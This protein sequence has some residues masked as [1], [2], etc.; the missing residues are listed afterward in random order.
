MKKWIVFTVLVTGLSALTSGGARPEGVAAYWNCYHD[1]FCVH[2]SMAEHALDLYSNDELLVNYGN[3]DFGAGHEDEED[4]VWDIGWPCTTNTHFWDADDP[5]WNNPMDGSV[6]CTSPNAWQKAHVL[7]GMALGEYHSGDTGTAYFYLGHVVHLLGDMT[8]PAHVH[9]DPHPYA[10]AYED[11]FTTQHTALSSSEWDSLQEMGP[12]EIPDGVPKL[13]WLFYTTNQ[14]G[15]YY[16]SDD[17]DGDSDDPLHWADFSGLIDDPECRSEDGFELGD[18]DLEVVRSNSY[19]YSI[20]AVAALYK[21]FAEESKQQADLTVVIDSVQQLQGHGDDPDYYVWASIGGQP[22]RNEGV[23]EEDVC[24]DCTVN[25]GW[26]FGWNVGLTGAT[27]VVIELWDGDYPDDDDFSDIS[28]LDDDRSLALTIDLAKCAAGEGGAVSGDVAGA[29]GV[30]LTSA[31]QEDDRSQIWFRILAPNVPPTADAGPDQ[32][33]DE[34]AVVTLNGSFTDPND[35]DPHTF[36]WEL[37]DSSGTNCVDVPD[38]T[39]QTLTFAPIDDCVY[40]FGFTVTDN[41]GAQGS[42]TVVVTV[43]NVPPVASIDRLTDETGAEIG[44]DVPVALVGLEVDLAG[45]FTDVGIVDTHTASL[46][47]GDGE[48]YTQADFDS[49]SDCLGWATGSLNARHIYDDPG[50]YTITLN[51]TDDDAGVG[52]TTAQI[53]VVDAAGAIAAVVESLTPLSDDPK[54]QAAIDKLQG[55]QDGR[56]SNGAID[57]LEQG[58]PNAALEKIK[59]ALGYLA[60][61]EAADPSLDLTH[62]KGLLALAGKSVAVGAIAEAEA[63]AFKPADLLKIQQAKDLVAQGDA[64]LAAHN[65][66]GSVDK[67]QQAVRKVQNIH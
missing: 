57:K 44:V 43:E 24:T 64:L 32:T 5:D 10:D 19:L 45:S 33:V 61:A 26:A 7:W 53:E 50:V 56:A 41:H 31:G 36:L 20:R 8:V 13:D 58:N 1:G 17:Y 59:Q 27:T 21:L 12:V 14:V 63:V 66:V 6:S 42:D 67:D 28:P 23:Q 38:S 65:Y 3:V 48:V 55:E 54:I 30:Q 25:P 49:F 22:F 18:C 52:T 62:D 46:D 11:W 34:N 15:D 47:W 9:E 4:L 35:D 37:E 60:A 2:E 40:T 16:A 29:C 39:T 51:V